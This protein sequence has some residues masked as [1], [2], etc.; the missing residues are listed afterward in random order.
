MNSGLPANLAEVPKARKNKSPL[1]PGG[2]LKIARCAVSPNCCELTHGQG[3][4][5]NKLARLE[6]PRTVWGSK[7]LSRPVYFWAQ[8]WAVPLIIVGVPFWTAFQEKDPAAVPTEG[9]T[10]PLFL[11][12]NGKPANQT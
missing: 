4:L 6:G 8:T 11:R 10:L 5:Q 1:A 9:I 12:L 3:C 7:S 2:C